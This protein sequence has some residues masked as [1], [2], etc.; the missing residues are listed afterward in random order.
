MKAMWLTKNSLLWYVITLAS[1]ALVIGNLVML[2]RG[3]RARRSRKILVCAGINLLFSFVLFLILMDCS[4]YAYLTEADPRYQPFQIALFELP[5]LVYAALEAV[6]AAVLFLLARDD[7]RYRRSHLTPDAIRETVDLLPEGICVSAKD[8][9]VLLS[10]LQMNTLCRRLTGG[11]LSDG[12]KFAQYLAEHGEK[13]NGEILVHAPDGRVWRFLR[14]SLQTNGKEY[15]RWTAADI[16]DTYRVTEE[17]RDKNE[18]L[19]ELQRRM[20]EVSE[21]SGDMFIAQEEAA[22]RSALHNQLG[23]V[24]LM[25]RHYLEHPE[26]TD[27]KMVAMATGEMNRFLLGEAEAPTGERT[28]RLQQAI[29]LA[30]SIGVRTEIHGDEPKDPARR[31]LLAQVI[32]ECAANTVKHAE[33]DRIDLFPEEKDGSWSVRITN[34]GRPPKGPVAESG[35]LLALRRHVEEAGG[36]MSVESTP[37][38]TLTLTIP[39]T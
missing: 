4:R 21:L 1:I 31:A 11:S 34:N 25:G 39:G 36:T 15:D 29:L 16:T 27:A 32:Q 17:L 19:Q 24:L 10:N 22:A 6:S 9:T 7:G 28:D 14:D 30:K 3:A 38:F 26:N 23:Q 2:I 5:W 35:G 8:G 12:A 37:A 18:H 20:K 33:G 13:K